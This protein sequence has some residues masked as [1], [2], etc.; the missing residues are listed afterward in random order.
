MNYITL[1][2]INIIGN[3]ITFSSSG[4]GLSLFHFEGTS[5]NAS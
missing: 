2:N 3:N 1:K 4:L 5:M